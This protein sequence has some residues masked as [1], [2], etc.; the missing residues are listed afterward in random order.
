MPLPYAG[1]FG[2]LADGRFSG[3]R[4]SFAELVGIDGI[5]TPGILKARQKLTKETDSNA[6][7]ELCK[8]AIS[9]SSSAD[10]SFWFSSESGKVWRR[11]SAGV[12]TLVFTT[13]PTGGGAGCLGAEEFDGYL[14]WATEDHLHRIPVADIGS[15]S[16]WTAN[17]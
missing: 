16:A 14:Y 7:D 6:P 12:W 10:N 13:V 3:M 5:S 8:V 1:Q 11:S 4:G 15:A 2:G 17:E 9:L